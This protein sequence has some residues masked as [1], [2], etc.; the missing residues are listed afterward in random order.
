M[1]Q[2][3]SNIPNIPYKGIL[4]LG[5]QETIIYRLVFTNLGFRPYLPFSTFWAL[6]KG[7]APQVPQ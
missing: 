5:I 6:Q 3:V 7:V 1:G 2:K 4:F